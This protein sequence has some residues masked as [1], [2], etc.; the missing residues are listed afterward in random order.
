[1]KSLYQLA[2]DSARDI[3]AFSPTTLEEQPPKFALDLA[4]V[5]S[6][7]LSDFEGI[8][9]FGKPPLSEAHY[10]RYPDHL[11]RYHYMGGLCW[12]PTA[13]SLSN[14]RANRQKL[15]DIAKRAVSKLPPG[16][17]FSPDA[18]ACCYIRRPYFGGTYTILFRQT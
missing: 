16:S 11:V 13:Q 7:R 5:G 4:L 17:Y 6:A 10:R 18:I 2:L 1:M 14:I 12:Q 3:A 15:I 8:F 9:K